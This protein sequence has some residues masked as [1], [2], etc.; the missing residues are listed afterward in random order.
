MN[1]GDEIK[2]GV[3]SLFIT[4]IVL[5]IVIIVATRILSKFIDNN[6]DKLNEIKTKITG[7]LGMGNIS[8]NNIENT[9]IKN[10][11]SKITKH[12]GNSN[13]NSNSNDNNSNSNLMPNNYSPVTSDFP[14]SVFKR[15]PLNKEFFS[16]LDTQSNE[17]IN[18]N[19]DNNLASQLNF[20]DMLNYN[21]S[22]NLD[23]VDKINM[24]R[25]NEGLEMDGKN[26]SE[27]Y[28]SILYTNPHELKKCSVPRCMLPGTDNVAT[29]TILHQDDPNYSHE[30]SSYDSNEF[31]GLLLQ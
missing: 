15:S 2:C 1:I 8:I 13:S 17:S 24:Y 19:V 18:S 27:V 4:L 3:N 7:V 22:N 5:V 31:S 10:I 28:K 16:G 20:N 6:M 30:Y 23:A 9:N 11:L 26:V 12:D 21:S 25:E 29:N 14:S